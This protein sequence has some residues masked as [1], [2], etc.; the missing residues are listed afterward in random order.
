MNVIQAYSGNK[1]KTTVQARNRKRLGSYVK[2]PKGM[3]IRVLPHTADVEIK[4]HGI[5]YKKLFE[6]NLKAMS[7]IL[8][9]GCCDMKGHFDCLIKLNITATDPTNLLVDFL[10]E[11]LSL[12]YV[13]KA[14]FC[15]IYF[16]ELSNTKID[17]QLYGKW[18]DGFDEEIKGVTYHEAYVKR[19]ED[20]TWES[21][22]IFDI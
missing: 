4:V 15:N 3:D 9:E 7:N 13:Q 22:I 10:S 14:L 17:A 2:S 20:G 8:K 6:N 5:T 1:R 11:I 12:T 21:H 18:I 16:S 19:N